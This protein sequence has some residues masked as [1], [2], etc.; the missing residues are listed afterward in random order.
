MIS[1]LFDEWWNGEWKI[2]KRRFVRLKGE[3]HRRA[4]KNLKKANKAKSDK[5][6]LKT[7]REKQRKRE[8]KQREDERIARAIEK[9]NKSQVSRP[10]I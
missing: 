7:Q 8:E 9:L 6:E 3:P 1:D 5:A 2:K 4:L 10:Y